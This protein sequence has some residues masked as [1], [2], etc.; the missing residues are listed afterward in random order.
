MGINTLDQ[1]RNC[2]DIVPSQTLRL[3]RCYHCMELDT[4]SAHRLEALDPEALGT[5]VNAFV[6]TKGPTY[7]AYADGMHASFVRFSPM[8]I[9][10]CTVDQTSHKLG[11]LRIH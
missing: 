11:E 5:F 8:A 6:S 4:N 3:Y 2:R 7:R 10:Y 9:I 1:E